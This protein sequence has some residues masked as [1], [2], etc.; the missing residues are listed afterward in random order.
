MSPQGFIVSQNTPLS[1]YEPTM[2]RLQFEI[3]HWNRLE[4][5]LVDKRYVGYG[6][7][8]NFPALGTPAALSGL[9]RD[10]RDIRHGLQI[11][12]TLARTPTKRDSRVPCDSGRSRRQQ[13]FDAREQLLGTR[14]K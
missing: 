1:R 3:T 9:H 8:L 14:K 10:Q 7:I 12:A 6:H 5:M 4:F 13:R 2:S 11:P